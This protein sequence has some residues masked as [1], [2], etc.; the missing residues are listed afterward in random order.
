MLNK[1][2]LYSKDIRGPVNIILHNI[3]PAFV[4]CT[5][6]AVVYHCLD[7]LSSNPFLNCI[8]QIS[9]E[10]ISNILDLVK[11]QQ[12]YDSLR[13]YFT[14]KLSIFVYVNQRLLKVRLQYI[15]YLNT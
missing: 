11:I 3:S 10:K 5:L 1:V 13:L 12:K 14:L 9:D 15:T 8:C 6:F 7:I 4:L 2:D